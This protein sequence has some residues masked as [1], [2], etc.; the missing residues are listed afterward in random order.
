MASLKYS[1]W[2]FWRHP[3]PEPDGLNGWEDAV[4][5]SAGMKTRAGISEREVARVERRAREDGAVCA[6]DIVG[7]ILKEIDDKN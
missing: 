7:G 5:P 4:L 6:V 3:L 1:R 2:V